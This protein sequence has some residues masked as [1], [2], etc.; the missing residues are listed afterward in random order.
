[1]LSPAAQAAA[2]ASSGST[3]LQVRML[4]GDL[5]RLRKQAAAS[6]QTLAEYVRAQLGV[7]DPPRGGA[8][9]GAGR[10]NKRAVRT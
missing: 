1:M 9:P 8:R 2:L 3:L 5:L 10:G 7:A 6:K 4:T